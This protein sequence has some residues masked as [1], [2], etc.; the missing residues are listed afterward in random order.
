MIVYISGPITGIKNN[1]AEAFYKMEKALKK[2]F[3]KLPY[4]K[5]VNPQ[6][7][8]IRV[9]A[10]FK[11]ISRVLKKEK[12]PRWE[13]YMRAC[14]AELAGCS[15]VVVLENYKK[16]KGVKVELFLAKLLGIPIFFSLEELRNNYKRL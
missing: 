8:A 10:Y 4:F 1:N 6:R 3:E 2:S 5:I 9:D 16:S 12:L 15:H 7:L 13:D 11:E 14:I